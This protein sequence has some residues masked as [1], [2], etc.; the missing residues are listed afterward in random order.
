MRPD[1][2]TSIARQT[3]DIFLMNEEMTVILLDAAFGSMG[4]SVCPVL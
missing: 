1:I 4:R 3:G 2:C